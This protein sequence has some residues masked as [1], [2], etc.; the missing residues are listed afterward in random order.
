[1]LCN[2]HKSICDGYISRILKR[3]AQ[4]KEKFVVFFSSVRSN[5]N[6]LGLRVRYASR[7]KLN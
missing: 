6:I 7:K 2:I 4:E 3:P 5:E 1:M